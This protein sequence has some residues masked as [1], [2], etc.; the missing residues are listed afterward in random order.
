MIVADIGAVLA[1]VDAD[2]R[3][4]ESLRAIFERFGSFCEHGAVSR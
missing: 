4:H 1:L 3:Y 2:D